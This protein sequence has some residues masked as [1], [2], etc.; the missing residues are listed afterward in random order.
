MRSAS[1]E[2]S[3]RSSAARSCRF[4]FC[5]CASNSLWVVIPAGHSQ[6]SAAMKGRM[7]LSQLINLNWFQNWNLTKLLFTGVGTT[8][9]SGCGLRPISDI[10]AT[11]LKLI[12]N[13]ERSA[14]IL[15]CSC[16]IV[17]ELVEI[18][19]TRSFAPLRDYRK[20]SRR[21]EKNLDLYNALVNIASR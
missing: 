9:V 11:S 5:F 20:C 7:S 10:T 21:S 16:S 12:R 4:V 14:A 13:F 3:R 1:A 18:V 15:R 2:C 19:K 17:R 6:S 8:H